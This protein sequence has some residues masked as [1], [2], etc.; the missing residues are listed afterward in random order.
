MNITVMKKYIV[1]QTTV[2]KIQTR[3]GLLTTS[4]LQMYT[5]TESSTQY[6]KENNTSGSNYNVWNDDWSE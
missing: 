4:A 6:V 1:P 5:D 2:T 3:H